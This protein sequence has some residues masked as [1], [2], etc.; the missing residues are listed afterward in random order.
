MQGNEPTFRQGLRVLLVEDEILIA[1]DCEALL[2]ALGV[3]EVR[4]VR[5]VAEG[6][7]ALDA[8]TF[9]AAILDVRLG[10]EDSMPLARRLDELGVPFGFVSGLADDAIPAE[11]RRRP[12]M[13]KPF[14]L[15]EVQK[16]LSA[17]LG[18]PE[19]RQA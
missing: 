18:R 9:D 12:Q 17:V 15:E 2:L 14:N 19:S 5:N 13:P 7:G 16:L 10:S 11:L 1:L 3:S 4:R 6:L 8:E